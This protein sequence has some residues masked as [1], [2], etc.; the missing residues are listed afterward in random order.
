[1]KDV[2]HVIFVDTPTEVRMKRLKEREV[3][4]YGE[5]VQEGGDM[6]KGSLE[7]LAWAERYEDPELEVGRSRVKHE[8]WLRAVKVPVT[9]LVGEKEEGVLVREALEALGSGEEVGSEEK[10]A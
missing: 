10:R 1:M 9:R 2:E 7:F 4:R 6:N 8:E 5:R 3:L